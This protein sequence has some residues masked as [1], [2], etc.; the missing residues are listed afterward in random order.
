MK[1]TS[2]ALTLDGFQVLELLGE[3][4]HGAV[5]KARQDST[6]QL[7]ALKFLQADSAHTPFQR[8]R[9]IARFERET[10]LCAQLHHPHIV[11]L[12]DRGHTPAQQM[13]AVYEF[14]PGITLKDWLLRHG[15]LN[16]LMAGEIMTQL[17][18]A[19]A[20]AHAQ[21]IVHRDLKPQNIMLSD[22][23]AS[24]HTKILDFGIAAMVPE[25][26]HG[27]VHAAG[28]EAIGT[29]S[30]SA[31]EQ[32]R[33]EAATT[34]TDLY[35]WGLL[36]L[37]CLTG[38]AAISGTTLAE[39]FHKQL[40]PQEVALPPALLRHPLGILLRRVLQKDS[41]ERAT[42]AR[43]LYAELKSMN[44]LNI[45]GE[46]HPTRSTLRDAPHTPLQLT[47][48]YLPAS[49]TGQI[50]QRQITVMCCSLAVAPLAEAGVELDALEALETL[51]RDQLNL[52]SDTCQRHGAYLAGSLG[53]NLMFYFGYPQLHQDDAQRAARTALDLVAQVR[54]R[55][56]LLEQQLGVRLEM[57]IAIHTGMVLAR[58]GHPPHGLTPD[59]A[60]RLN[61][62]AK[63]G[64]VLVSLDSRRLLEAGFELHDTGPGL[65]DSG[66][67]TMPVSLLSGEYCAD[68]FCFL[69]TRASLTPYVGQIPA[70]QT[71]QRLWHGV[72]QGHGHSAL[73]VANAG[74]G[75]SRLAY[76]QCHQVRQQ[77]GLTR[78][79]RC[80]PEHK[81]DEL[82]PFLRL[83]KSHYQLHDDVAP[84]LATRRLQ[85]ALQACAGDTAHALPVLCSWLALPLPEHVSVPHFAVDR[86]KRLLLLTLQKLILH[87]GGGAAF[88]LVFEDIH[89]IDQISFELLSRII[90]VAPQHRLLLILTSRPEFTARWNPHFLEQIKLTRLSAADSAQL[91]G[92]LLEQ[93]PLP[94]PDMQQL[95]ARVD[96]IPLFA[97][98]LVQMLQEQK[99]LVARDNK[100]HLLAESAGSAI[101]AGLQAFLGERLSHLGSARGIAQ[102]AA[103]IGREFTHELLLNASL[104]DEAG[105]QSAL[106]HMIAARLICRQ[107][108]VHGD[109]YIFRHA[110]LRDAAY[111]SIPPH[112]RRHVH[113]RIA[114]A[115]ENLP[116]AQ[117][118]RHLGQLAEHFA[119]AQEFTKAIQ[120]AQRARQQAALRGLAADARRHA[121]HVQLWQAR[122]DA[123]GSA[124]DHGDAYQALSEA[125][126]L[127]YGWLDA[128]LAAQA[129]TRSTLKGKRPPQCRL[130]ESLHSIEQ[131]TSLQWAMATYHHVASNR[132]TVRE[133]T[134]QLLALSNQS[135]DHNQLKF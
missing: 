67:R 85:S 71:L 29:P 129:K 87:M 77:G 121:H 3:G 110:L 53:D 93:K 133:L 120:Y 88:L 102:L 6:G 84:Q 1:K 25:M 69:R 65:H 126:M 54:K 64:T 52:C 30:Y 90:K 44:L 56:R 128:H 98:E 21:G 124:L 107:R 4:G 105:I 27:A 33:G 24:L 50:E 55:S 15:A 59:I 132:S 118:E 108:R 106:D 68:A 49:A 34:R 28:A 31:P 115:M 48:D 97:E 81:N 61:R 38:K 114:F 89:W 91:L 32:L 103:A 47:L 113:A 79:A 74:I 5:Y 125:L 51:Q 117:I 46:L 7:V 92:N 95:L 72:Q 57:C 8:Q 76:E 66:S 86:Q 70:L 17:L 94:A 35:A 58:P 18:D 96:G 10:R 40:S 63:P 100:W 75:K 122:L 23:G 37:E 11:R 130:L 60:L 116:P 83:L 123:S 45:G 36:F 13:F 104:P 111:E 14:V 62:M 19:L 127:K 12:L 112:L 41:R 80:L 43:S 42:D 20:C 135:N 82:Y 2:A 99:A 131:A 26:Q 9:L 101:P 73:I 109:L 119:Q 134:D 39:I 22:T 16:V 78:E